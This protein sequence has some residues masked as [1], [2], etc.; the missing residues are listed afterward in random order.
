[1]PSKSARAKP[2]PSNRRTPRA[3]ARGASPD[4]APDAT[5]VLAELEKLG[6]RK[7]RENMAPRYG[8]HA[9]KAHGVPMSR[10]LQLAK[11]LGRNHELALALWDTGWYE[12]RL[13]AAM[14]DEPARVTVAQMDRWCRSFENWGDCDTVCFKLFDQVPQAY[15]RI[16]PWSKRPGAMER[17]AACALLACLALHDRDAPDAD[18]A[19]HLPLVARAAADEEP[20]VRKG[21]IWAL[22]AIGRRR[23]LRAQ[24]L[25]V[26]R[27][28]AESADAGARA[29]GKEALREITKAAKG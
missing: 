8:I 10:L 17:R 18:F 5:Q 23:G 3:T 28:L 7:T 26:A 12:A 15:G 1:M 6:D 9:R 2:S 16:A 20:L 21:A 19:R 13:L 22:R 4:V 29:A 27:K 11:R 25:E 14:I 24:A